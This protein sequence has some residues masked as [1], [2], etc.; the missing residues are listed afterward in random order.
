MAPRLGVV[1]HAPNPALRSPEN[2]SAFIEETAGQA[3]RGEIAPSI[4]MALVSAANAALRAHE[5]DL[6]RRLTELEHLAASRAKPVYSSVPVDEG[7]EDDEP[8]A[9]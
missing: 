7:K 1:P 3:R 9:P 6:G 4:A 5:A 2:I 8:E